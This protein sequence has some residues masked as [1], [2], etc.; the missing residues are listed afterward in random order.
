MLLIYKAGASGTNRTR[1][2]VQVLEDMLLI[3]KGQALLGLNYSC[4]QY[5]RSPRSLTYYSLC[6]TR[7]ESLGALSVT[8]DPSHVFK[9]RLKLSKQYDT[10][11]VSFNLKLQLASHRSAKMILFL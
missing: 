2:F 10:L 5:H 7:F 4:G 9:V 11:A 8:Y 6:L 3:C 1:S